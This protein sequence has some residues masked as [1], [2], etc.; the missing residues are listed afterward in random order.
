MRDDRKEATYT[1]C[2]LKTSKKERRKLVTRKV[3]KRAAEEVSGGT[4]GTLSFIAIIPVAHHPVHSGLLKQPQLG[5]TGGRR[6]SH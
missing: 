6:S 3:N 2:S 4:A 1:F 5:Q